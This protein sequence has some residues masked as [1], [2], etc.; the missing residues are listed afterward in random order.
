MWL[1]EKP[2]EP[3]L[4]MS[5]EYFAWG[6]FNFFVFQALRFVPIIN[7]NRQRIVPQIS[8]Y[9][10]LYDADKFSTA[11]TADICDFRFR[12]FV[13]NGRLFSLTLQGDKKKLMLELS[14]SKLCLSYGRRL[15][16]EICTGSY[17]DDNLYHRVQLLQKSQEELTLVL[18]G[19]ETGFALQ[20]RNNMTAG[21]SIES[22]DIA[23]VCMTHLLINGRL[24]DL[25][26]KVSCKLKPQSRMT[27]LT[28]ST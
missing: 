25:T 11:A 5:F 10:C 9:A 4:P 19:Q 27:F 7:S 2:A 15:R 18:D 28:V 6:I 17:L 23:E 13:D 1:T 8:L 26:K 12:S 20:N 21:F 22:V 14:R 3:F 24:Q 16:Q